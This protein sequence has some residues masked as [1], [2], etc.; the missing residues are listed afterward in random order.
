VNPDLVGSGLSKSR[1]PNIVSAL[2]S[3]SEILRIITY[4][5]SLS[6]S[7]KGPVQDTQT[8]ENL[9]NRPDRLRSRRQK[10]LLQYGSQLAASLTYHTAS[11]FAP[12]DSQ[13]ILIP[14]Y[15]ARQ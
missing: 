11:A 9:S 12:Q 5:L 2:T 4:L 10:I 6:S 3:Y 7:R 15:V 14:N 1:L 8:S 13:S